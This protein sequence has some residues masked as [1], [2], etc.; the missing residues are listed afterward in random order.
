[1]FILKGHGVSVTL[2]LTLTLF[3]IDVFFLYIYTSAKALTLSRNLCSLS[4]YC[5]FQYPAN[6]CKKSNFILTDWPICTY[7][8]LKPSPYISTLFHL[9]AMFSYINSWQIPA[10]TDSFWKVS[11]KKQ[12]KKLLSWSGIL[13]RRTFVPQA[14][15]ENIFVKDVC[16]ILVT[17]IL[18]GNT[19]RILPHCLSILK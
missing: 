2:F 13:K 5:Y 8:E 16:W 9:S 4:Y 12:W 15:F 10:S 17:W 1:M 11:T 6:T 3:N 19:L 18:F 14:L 7:I